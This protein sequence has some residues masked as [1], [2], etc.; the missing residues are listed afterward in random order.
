MGLSNVIRGAGHRIASVGRAV[1]AASR[2]LDQSVTGQPPAP[3]QP[4]PQIQQAQPVVPAPTAPGTPAE[5]A[6]QAVAPKGFSLPELGPAPDANAPEFQGET[7][8]KKYEMAAAEY[9][10]KQDIHQAFADLDKVYTEAH[11]QRDFQKEFT[12]SRAMQAQHDAERPKG[13][14]LARAALAL[15]DFNPAVQQS[16]RS[17]LDTYNQGVEK[18]GHKSDQGFSQR[19]TLRLKMH[20]QSAADAEAKGNWKKALAEQEKLALLKNDSEA[21]AHKRD[22]E[23]EEAKLAGSETRANIRADA[24]QRAAKIRSSVIGSSHGLSGT[25]LATFEKEAAKSVAKLLGPHDLTKEYTQADLD[26]M[27]N[28]I[29]QLAEMFHDQQYGDGSSDKYLNTHP[30]KR[31]QPK[32]PPTKEEF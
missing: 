32:E 28:Y 17:N 29:E 1:Q 16:G 26:S 24:M 6:S 30:Q 11:P 10:H 21:I 8:K 31:P 7:G 4:S 19:M 5:G 27:T 14:N 13:N 3:M 2:K 23:K 12:E 15:G 9:Q 20:E 22:M 25:F 18:A